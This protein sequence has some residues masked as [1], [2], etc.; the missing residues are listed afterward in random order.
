MDKVSK[1][2][3][4]TS[5]KRSNPNAEIYQLHKSSILDFVRKKSQKL[6]DFSKIHVNKNKSFQEVILTL[7]NLYT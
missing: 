1:T 5:D 3:S 7:L 2:C 6:S 4:I